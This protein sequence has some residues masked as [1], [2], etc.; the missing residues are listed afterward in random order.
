MSPERVPDRQRDRVGGS[1]LE[2]LE[3][4]TPLLSVGNAA[5]CF[6]NNN[7]DMAQLTVVQKDILRDMCKDLQNVSTY[8]GQLTAIQKPILL[9]MCKPM[10]Q[11]TAIQKDILRDVGMDMQ[12]HVLT[13]T[14]E[15]KK[16]R[17]EYLFGGDVTL[18]CHHHNI[19]SHVGKVKRG[20][21]FPSHGP[22]RSF[23]VHVQVG[24][25]AVRIKGETFRLPDAC[26]MQMWGVEVTWVRRQG[27]S[28]PIHSYPRKRGRWG[29][30]GPPRCTCGPP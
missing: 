7:N 1:A 25:A 12:E 19:M 16:W 13:C 23:V 4:K 2:D 28:N 24:D 10:P 30:L 17:R 27:G 18:D 3:K 11:L 5:R 15:C 14:H 21:F 22:K 20:M 26:G 29:E 6:D 9:D 8:M